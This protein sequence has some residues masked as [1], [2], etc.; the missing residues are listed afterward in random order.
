MSEKALQTSK[1][2]LPNGKWSYRGYVIEKE[3]SKWCIVKGELTDDNSTKVYD[4]EA[5]KT[6]KN[7]CLKIDEILGDL[8]NSQ[9]SKP[10]RR[11]KKI[12]EETIN[13][14]L[15]EAKRIAYEVRTE[16]EDILAEQ[17]EETMEKEKGILAIPFGQGKTVGK[18]G[19]ALTWMKKFEVLNSVLE[20]IQER[21]PKAELSAEEEENKTVLTVLIK[22]E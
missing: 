5:D 14:T 4:L 9:A 7:V 21:N 19:F 6:I 2:K 22:E 1:K 20:S 10:K 3:N 11:K 13:A 15:A 16:L 12:S 8:P 18:N 17:S